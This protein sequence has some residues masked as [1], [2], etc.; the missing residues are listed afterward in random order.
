MTVVTRVW[1]AFSETLRV[2][3]RGGGS[4]SS[5]QIMSVLGMLYI[6]VFVPLSSGDSFPCAHIGVG[7]ASIWDPAV[8][9]F[10]QGLGILIFVYTG[11]SMVTGSTLSFHVV[12]EQI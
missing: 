1:R 3:Y 4:I 11:R 6:L 2:D 7:L 12:K 8:I 9:L 5:Y 10:L